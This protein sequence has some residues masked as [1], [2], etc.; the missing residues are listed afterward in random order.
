M[1]ATVHGRGEGE[2]IGGPTTITIKA[3]ATTVTFGKSV[4]FVIDVMPLM[5]GF[6][7]PR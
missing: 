4:T 2:R 1:Q 6:I 3:S 5:R 7:S